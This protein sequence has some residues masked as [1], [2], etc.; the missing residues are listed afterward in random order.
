MDTLGAQPSLYIMPSK[1]PNQSVSYSSAVYIQ[2]QI[3]KQ[4]IYTG[5]AY[6]PISLKHGITSV[7]L[8]LMVK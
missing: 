7:A 3:K 8:Y 5:E 4:T 2:H 1:D 6:Q